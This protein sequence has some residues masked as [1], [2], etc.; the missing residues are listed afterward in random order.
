MKSDMRDGLD[1][2]KMEKKKKKERKV[3]GSA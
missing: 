1:K 3:Q 2:Q